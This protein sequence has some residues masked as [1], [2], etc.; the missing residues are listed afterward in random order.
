MMAEENKNLVTISNIG[1]KET[2]IASK[3]LNEDDL[4]EVKNL[5]RLFNLIQAKKNMLRVMNL[6][7]LFDK[8]S[9]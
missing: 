5:T 2:E 3:I 8:V 1:E 7:G 6:N 4:D 9:D